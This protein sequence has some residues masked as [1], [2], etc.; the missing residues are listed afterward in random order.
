MT[1]ATR[2]AGAVAEE[3]EGTG[4]LPLVPG[5]ALST[6]AR[7]EQTGWSEPVQIRRRSCFL[8][9]RDPARSVCSLLLRK[10]EM[11]VSGGFVS[12]RGKR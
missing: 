4:L 9:W 1:A 6:V 2:L 7:S 10:R 11:E 12:A 5:G 3:R 8:W